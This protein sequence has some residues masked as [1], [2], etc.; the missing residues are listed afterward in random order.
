MLNDAV[1]AKAGFRIAVTAFA[2]GVLDEQRPPAYGDGY[3]LATAFAAKVSRNELRSRTGIRS[4]VAA[5]A[6][7]LVRLLER[8][9]NDMW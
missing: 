4:N 3:L 1:S 8:L 2:A 9:I 6:I 7:T 5:T